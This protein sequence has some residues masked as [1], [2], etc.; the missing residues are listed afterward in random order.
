MDLPVAEE[1]KE[2]ISGDIMKGLKKPK[3]CPNFGAQMQ[4]GTSARRTDGKQRRLLCGIL[5]L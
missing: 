1:N 3:D 4:T 2:C 5:P